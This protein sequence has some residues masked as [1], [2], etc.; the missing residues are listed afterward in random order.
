MK[1]KLYLLFVISVISFSISAQNIKPNIP[2]NEPFKLKKWNEILP[3]KEKQYNFGLP[4]ETEKPRLLFADNEPF[5][6]KKWN[7]LLP[8]DQK[9][10][11]VELTTATENS[12]LN[13]ADNM[14]VYQYDTKDKMPIL[15]PDKKKDYSLLIETP[16]DL[17]AI[18]KDK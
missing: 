8:L 18:K 11:K 7:E 1:L 14:P 13:Y 16:I 4:I 2:D 5:K 17:N 15:M 12:Q 10:S 9:Q 3:L 6:L